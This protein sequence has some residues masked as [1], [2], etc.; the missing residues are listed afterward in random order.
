MSRWGLEVVSGCAS[1]FKITIET[2]RTI[3]SLPTCRQPII[4]FLCLNSCRKKQDKMWGNH[5]FISY[6]LY[7]RNNC[8]G[9]PI[10]LAYGTSYPYLRALLIGAT[11]ET[12]SGVAENHSFV[13]FF[14]PFSIG[15]I[16]EIP[17]TFPTSPFLSAPIFIESAVRST[18]IERF[19]GW[20]RSFSVVSGLV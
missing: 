20:S 9:I 6:F 16:F 11:V 15:I 17:P 3:L 14:I 5:G 19:S 2:G 4:T 10:H 1:I 8:S 12:R 7:C 13:G 18:E